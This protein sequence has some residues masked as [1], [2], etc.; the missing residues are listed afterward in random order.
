MRKI[1]TNRIAEE[2]KKEI[3]LIIQREMKD[4]RIDGLISITEV[5][6]TNDLS[7]AKIYVTCY[8]AK[9]KQKEVL[10][11]LKNA[12]GYF[13]SELGKRIKLRT[14]PELIFEFDTSLEY[15]N[16]INSILADL[17]K[18]QEEKNAGSAEDN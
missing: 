3:S 13:R 5:D 4:P 16:K 6:V 10:Q 1:R 11:V 18:E 8:A 7:Y 14:I 15:G 12:S 2:I 17:K 9:E